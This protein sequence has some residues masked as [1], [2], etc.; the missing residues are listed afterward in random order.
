MI[1]GCTLVR[2]EPFTVHS[3]LITSTS[4][5]ILYIYLPIIYIY[6]RQD[7]RKGRQDLGLQVP[8]YAEA[9]K[10]LQEDAR[11]SHRKSKLGHKCTKKRERGK[12]VHIIMTTSENIPS[13][14]KVHPEN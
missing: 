13:M 3:V 5:S 7:L 6:I 9:K 10:N 8:E 12:V 14:Q 1:P 4:P 11:C 2:S